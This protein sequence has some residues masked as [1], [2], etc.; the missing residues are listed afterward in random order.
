MDATATVVRRAPWNKGKLVGPKSPLKVKDIW[1]IAGP[2]GDRPAIGRFPAKF[3]RTAGSPIADVERRTRTRYSRS[4]PRQADMDYADLPT[5]GMLEALYKRSVDGAIGL[6]R[7]NTV[8]RPLRAAGRDAE[9]FAVFEREC[10]RAAKAK[11]RGDLGDGH[12]AF[13]ERAVRVVQ[14]QIAHV[15]NRR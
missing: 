4:R 10:G 7:V 5:P 6:G 15:R 8:R 13:I 1:A 9:A 3:G 11:T 14:P 12:I 2:A